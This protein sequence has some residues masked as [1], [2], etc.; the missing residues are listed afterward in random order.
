MRWAL[1]KKNAFG[2]PAGFS[3]IFSPETASSIFAQ[4]TR[5]PKPA[6]K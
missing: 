3:E 5:P 1:A 2:F 4:R 6:R